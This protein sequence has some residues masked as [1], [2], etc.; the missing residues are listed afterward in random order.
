MTQLIALRGLPASGK[1][2]RAK[3]WVK[4]DPQNRARVNRDDLRL[5]AHDGAHVTQASVPADGGIGGT[6]RI[7]VA[8][9]DA[10]IHSLLRHGISVVV[11]ET[12][13][14]SRALRDLR[15]IAQ[16][17]KAEF[18]VWDMTNVA[19]AECVHRN[20]MREGLARVPEAAIR[21]MYKRFI[22]GKGYPLPVADDGATPRDDAVEPYVPDARRP[23]AVIVDIDG[24]VALHGTRNPYDYSRVHEDRPNEAVVD[25]VKLL[26]EEGYEII[27]CSGRDEASRKETL[28][29]L[30]EHLSLVNPCLFMRPDGDMRKDRVVKLELF[31]KYIRHEYNVKFVL[32][33]R[34]QV[35]DMWREL[36][37]PCFQVAPGDF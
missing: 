11:D 13:L 36:G 3:A 26:H 29:W 2:T 25:L 28:A 30:Q 7:I 9:R 35:V 20:A 34:S 12:C 32:D 27:F 10:L 31:D 19:L 21:E 33:D 6:E 1:T 23:E 8:A 17:T 14:K 22:E 16:V 18:I 37:L 5:M 24:T 15:H 4:E